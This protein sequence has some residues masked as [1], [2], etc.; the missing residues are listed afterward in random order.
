MMT[1]PVADDESELVTADLVVD[2]PEQ[3]MGGL[4]F[5]GFRC[6]FPTP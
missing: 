4:H 2:D 3:D 5:F 1:I 6:A